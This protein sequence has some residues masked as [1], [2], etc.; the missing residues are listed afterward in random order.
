M[1]KKSRRLL[2]IDFEHFHFERT[3]MTLNKLHIIFYYAA[4]LFTVGANKK[5]NQQRILIDGIFEKYTNV[6][7]STFILKYLNIYN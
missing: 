5:S 1:D 6:L 7:F 3:N 4:N 2:L